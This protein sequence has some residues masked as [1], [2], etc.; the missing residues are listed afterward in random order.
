MSTLAD[1][2]VEVIQVG[3]TT[4]RTIRTTWQ[5]TNDINCLQYH[6]YQVP[7]SPMHPHSSTP[8]T[9]STSRQQTFAYYQAGNNNQKGE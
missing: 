6:T 3:R 1:V 5:S 8:F 9:I 4:T 7:M 2:E